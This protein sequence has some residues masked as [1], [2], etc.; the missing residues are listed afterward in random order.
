M[1]W[2]REQWRDVSAYEGDSDLAGVRRVQPRALEEQCSA[3]IESIARTLDLLAFFADR[4][5]V[6]LRDKG[7]RHDLI[8]AVFA[9]PGQDDLLMIVRR[10]EALGRFLDTDD[11]KNLLVGYRRAAN[12]VARRGEEGR[13]G[14]LRRRARSRAALVLPEETRSPTRSPRPARRR[15]SASRARIS[16]GR[17]ARSRACARRSTRSSSASPSTS[18]TPALRLNRLRLLGE[19]RDAVHT[20]ADFSKIAG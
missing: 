1:R 19:L 9:L 7:A 8:D 6:Y 17:C 2:L 14:R 4:L 11:G 16:R 5:K 12:I 10:V 13:R 20:V 3:R 15:A 18:T